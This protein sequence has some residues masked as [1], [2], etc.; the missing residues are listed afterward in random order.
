MKHFLA[1]I[2]FMG[3]VACG[4]L[5]IN[6]SRGV[7]ATDSTM[8]LARLHHRAVKRPIAATSWMQPSSKSKTLLYVSDVYGNVVYVFNYPKL[9]P[10]GVLTGF[11][12]P[13][14][15]CND[16]AGDIWVANT[17]DSELVE[18]ARGSKT[19]KN[20][21]KDPNEAPADCSVDRKSGDLAVTNIIDNE[22]GPGSVSIYKR[23]SGKPKI[24]SDAAFQREFYLSYDNHGTIWLDGQNSDGDFVYASLKNGAFTNVALSG[25]TIDFAGGVAFVDGKITVGDQ[26]GPNGYSI[27]YQTDGSTITSSTPLLSS[28]DVAQYAVDGKHVFGPDALAESLGFWRYPSG[29]DEIRAFTYG[30]DVPLGVA[31]SK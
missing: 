30:W 25:A 11:S 12:Q 20:V 9:T 26:Q 8:P 18:Y 31:L 7:S 21:L 4:G 27:V 10:A 23:A 17:L 19:P 16:S 3:L 13:E 22:G 29:G 1:A 15:L 2:S 5:G 14:G 6:S 28:S 24:Y